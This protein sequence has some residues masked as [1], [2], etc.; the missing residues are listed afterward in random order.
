MATE[1]QK[2]LP[3]KSLPPVRVVDLG[4]EKQGITGSITIVGGKVTRRGGG[5]GS[6]TGGTITKVTNVDVNTAERITG[7]KASPNVQVTNTQRKAVAQQK[8]QSK[9]TGFTGV[10]EVRDQGGKLSQRQFI[11]NNRIVAEESKL[12]G[13]SP[14]ERKGKPTKFQVT[15]NKKGQVQEVKEERTTN[16]TA[17]QPSDLDTGFYYRSQAVFSNRKGKLTYFETTKEGNIVRTLSTE[18]V[19]KYNLR[20]TEEL[21]AVT[22][23]QEKGLPAFKRSSYNQP[24]INRYVSTPI[25]KGVTGVLRKSDKAVSEKLIFPV[26]SFIGKK[27][28]VSQ[29]DI[30]RY[31]AKETTKR[32]YP[33]LIRNLESS[34]SKNFRAQASQTLINAQINEVVKRPATTTAFLVSTSSVKFPKIPNKL[35]FPTR[36][37]NPTRTIIGQQP[38]QVGNVKT[39]VNVVTRAQEIKPPRVVIQRS[40]KGLLGVDDTLKVLPSKTIYTSGIGIKNVALTGTSRAEFNSLSSNIQKINFDQL[41]DL[42]SIPKYTTSKIPILEK[43]EPVYISQIQS[44]NLLAP[45]GRT[46]KLYTSSTTF[47]PVVENERVAVFRGYSTY[48][49]VTKPFARARGNVPRE[50]V[51]LFQSKELIKIGKETSK[52]Q[53]FKGGLGKQ[54]PLSKSFLEQQRQEIPLPPIKQPAQLKKVAP[55]SVKT[56]KTTTVISTSIINTPKAIQKNRV[57]PRQSSRVIPRQTQSLNQRSITKQIQPSK[58]LSKQVSIQTPKQ[59]TITQQAI[60][61]TQLQK[62]I[63]SLAL[64]RIIPTRPQPSFQSPPVARPVR[65]PTLFKAKPQPT[66]TPRGQGEFKLFVKERGTFK[67]RGAFSNPIRASRRGAFITGKTI[68]RSFKV[69]GSRPAPLPKGFRRSKKKGQQNVFV[70]LPKTALSQSTEQFQIQKARRFKAPKLI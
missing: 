37:L 39:S 54:T 70:E 58:S 65:I 44:K 33:V 12:T 67:F 30:S 18:E 52:V 4:N 55:V 46:T 40:S 66:P 27:T 69:T 5:G 56:P 61:Q 60:K 10:V 31:L 63:Q 41:K 14:Q 64:N 45:K 16:E 21:R 47:N 6:T 51:V 57:I 62:T 25:K 49:D 38:F 34:N 15:R 22:L 36:S 48:K 26:T 1:S 32:T 3:A 50:N 19:A 28:G 43:G 35:V 17:P 2:D 59:N 9:Q 29:S 68:S 13:Q 7:V 20:P 42:P 53:V 11:Q 23:E 24:A 8:Q